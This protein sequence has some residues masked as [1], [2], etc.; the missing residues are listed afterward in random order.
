MSNN[1]HPSFYALDALRLATPGTAADPGSRLR[2]HLKDC[3][4][5]SAYLEGAGTSSPEARP[6][7]WL[8][9]AVTAPAPPVRRS[10]HRHRRF[11]PLVPAFAAVAAASVVLLVGQRAE[12]PS[13]SFSPLASSPHGRGADVREKGTPAVRVFVKRGAKVFDWDGLAPVRSND[14]LR[15]EI[16]GAGKGFISV[17]ARAWD[18][19]PPT[20]IYEGALVSGPQL[21]PLSFQVDDDARADVV[22][23]ITSSRPIAAKLHT[24]VDEKRGA[25]GP[26]RQILVFKKEKPE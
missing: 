15:F 4:S 13:P 14:R 3:T 19:K 22:S 25:P 5:C 6:P 9:N 17:A 10:P 16:H 1:A 7:A 23:V 26:W 2:S 20:V 21:L 8:A 11:W 12:S 18:G 24:M